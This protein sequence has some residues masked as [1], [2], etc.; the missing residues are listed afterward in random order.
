MESRLLA[1]RR[2][3]EGGAAADDAVTAAALAGLMQ[4]IRSHR[5]D[6]TAPF[7]GSLPS[8]YPPGIPRDSSSEMHEPGRFAAP[9]VNGMIP[10]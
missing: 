9:S 4:L 6:L 8:P 10:G 2:L 1:R 7:S 3:C 5:G